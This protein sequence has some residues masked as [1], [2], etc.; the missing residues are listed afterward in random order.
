MIKNYAIALG[1]LIAGV[2]AAI[3]VGRS[4]QKATDNAQAE[5]VVTKELTR[6]SEKAETVKQQVNNLPATGPDSANAELRKD[7]SDN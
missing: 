5:A 7:W 4:K 3:F 2:A 6:I 1:L